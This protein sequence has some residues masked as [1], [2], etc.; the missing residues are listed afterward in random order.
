MQNNAFSKENIRKLQAMDPDAIKFS[1]IPLKQPF[2]TRDDLLYRQEENKLMIVLP[3][4]LR[5]EFM[6]LIHT[7]PVS[8]AH[9]GRDKSLARAKE[10]AWWPSITQDIIKFVKNCG[11]CQ[12]HKTPTHKF[13]E[14]KSIVVSEPCE[15]WAA[16]VAYLP[17]TTRGNK[18]VCKRYDARGFRAR[19]LSYV[20]SNYGNR[21]ARIFR[22]EWYN[23]NDRHM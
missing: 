9:Q 10:N 3:R 13:V 8:G 7:N 19:Y 14:L 2:T 5:L 22:I 21:C 15:V 20:K 11:V 6:N 17:K 23:F 18:G 4:K 16:D 12:K 1:T